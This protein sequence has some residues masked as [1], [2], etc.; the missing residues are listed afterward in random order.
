LTGR[1]AALNR[2]IS[3]STE[4]SLPIFQALKGTKKTS[5]GTFATTCIPRNKKLLVKAKHSYYTNPR[6]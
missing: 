1:L 5:H 6:G 4:Q 2:F 3:K